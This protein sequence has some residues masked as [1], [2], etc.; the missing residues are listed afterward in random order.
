M[1]ARRKIA[2]P[3]LSGAADLLQQTLNEGVANLPTL[4]FEHQ[5]AK[6]LKQQGIN[7]AK[8]LSQ[9]IAEYVLSG[10]TEPFVSSGGGQGNNVTLTITD[11]D[12]EEV[13]EGLERFCEEQLPSLIP[14]MAGKI[15]RRVLRD[16][17]SRWP[18]ENSLQEADIVAFR[19]QIEGRWGT[20]LG[21]LRMLLTM[22]R[23]WCQNISVRESRRRNHKNRRSRKLLI[24]LLVRACQ[25]TD[26]IQCLLENGFAD[27]AMARW[28]TLHEIAVVAAVILQ[29]GDDIAER[30]IAHQA[31]ESK[32]AMDKYIACSPHLGYQ[33]LSARAQAKIATAYDQAI[34]KYGKNFKSDY[35]WAASHMK[36]D[37]PTFADLEE[38]AGRAE[39]RSHYQMSNDNIHAGVKSL[40]VRLGLLGDYQGLL[41][42]RS[43]AG[44]TEP[45]QN[46]AHT[47]TQLSV[48]VCFSEPVFND[49]VIADMLMTLRDEIPRSF[50]RTDVQL[51]RD[52]RV[53]QRTQKPRAGRR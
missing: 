48:L 4:F 38:A 52:A 51:R 42:G 34:A 6:K 12:F 2:N 19:A 21:Q 45:G 25:V 49:Y 18:N 8:G 14:S 17:K 16:L 24:R 13:I 3:K 46:A 23:E 1:A 43:N 36:K 32:R 30:Y 11:S 26:E 50:A 37:R 9:R 39:M 27:G 28:R 10:S 31:V 7:A 15:S 29:H 41:A 53:I 20:P 44:L 40:Y 47:L 5:I 22:S 35:G 33:P